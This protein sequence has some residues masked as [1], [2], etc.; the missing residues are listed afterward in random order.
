VDEANFTVL[1]TGTI[2]AMASAASDW[3]DL[4]LTPIADAVGIRTG[5]GDDIIIN[6]GTINTLRTV[7]GVTT[8]GTAIDSGG[9]D[10]TIV[11]GDGSVTNGDIDLGTGSDTLSLEGTP[12][13]NGDIIDEMSS[14]SLSFNNNGSFD[15]SLP[16]VTAV[17]N[18]EGT[19][20]LSML[21]QMDYLEVNKG[22]LQLNNDYIFHENGK[23]QA[24][25]SGDGSY[26][27][28]LVNGTTS[29][30]GQLK[31]VRG[32]GAYLDGTTYEVL[33]AVN[34]IEKDTTFS[35]IELPEDKPL[36]K[37][38]LNQSENTVQVETDVKSFTT[39]ARSSNE[40]AVA[41]H[42]D[43]IL[44]TV[45]GDLNFALG[46]I[47]T[48]S[49][50]EEFASALYGLSPAAYNN[51]TLASITSMQQYTYAL[52]SRMSNLHFSEFSDPTR[53]LQNEPV[54]LAANGA[55]PQG[56]FI[57]DGYDYRYGIFVRGFGQHGAQDSTDD[58]Y[59]YDFT[60]NGIIV[61]FDHKFSNHYVGGASVGLANNDL[62]ADRDSSTGEIDSTLYSVYGSYLL[63]KG[64]I[65][66]VLSYGKN[67]YDTQRHVIIGATTTDVTSTHDGDLLSLGLSGGAY[68][69]LGNWWLRPYVSLQY[70]RLDEDGFT[71][72]GDGSSLNVAAR[73]TNALIS[74]L[75]TTFLRDYK[76]KGGHITPELNI[77]WNHDFDIDDHLINASYVG[78]PDA[79][80]SIEG[81]KVEENGIMLGAGFSYE[82]SSGYITTVKVSSEFRKNYNVNTIIGEFRYQF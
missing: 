42:W 48:L 10:D 56:L 31:V 43:N 18:G 54:M 21:N 50:G 19:F 40:M 7:N 69:S 59:G 2:N 6:Q 11:L 29:L 79:S 62:A 30:N 71:E 35:A 20:T 33:S 65:D 32:N 76:V 75:G 4:G 74:Q 28:F 57:R 23:F 25:V 38:Q 51:F 52:N 34:G 14:V 80:F 16:G 26:G 15:G 17:K 73:T 5:V 36:L 70:T 46:D 78:A 82:T 3:N 53:N 64:Y 24:T 63:N 1:N 22:T 49:S 61:G 41:K 8:L 66:A 77:A 68:Y 67:S 39:V 60:L 37:F 72:S 27:Q 13:I 12:V 55:L 44:P 45:N 81:Q 47:Q 9:G 58:N